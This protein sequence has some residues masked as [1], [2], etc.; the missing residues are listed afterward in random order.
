MQ[1]LFLMTDNHKVYLGL[2]SNLGNKE[3][4]ILVAIKMID[5]HVGAVKRQSGMHVTEPWGFESDNN[6]VNAAVCC[7]TSLSPRQ[8]LRQTQFIER[9]MGRL[10]KTEGM[11]YHDRIID[12][13]ILMYDD[14]VVDQSDLK[15]P[16]PLMNERD[17]VLKP[18]GE[19]IG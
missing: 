16:H 5:E 6:F 11:M 4:N 2:G 12:I 1:C 8:V 14:L 17:F 10:S 15:I 19:I 13:D 7:E 3:E 18:L 9:S